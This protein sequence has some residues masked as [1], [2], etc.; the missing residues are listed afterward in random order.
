MQLSELAKNVSIKI[1]GDARL[2]WDKRDEWQ[3][4]SNGYSCT[5]AYKKRRMKLD[6][7]MGSA[8]AHPPTSSDVLDVLL[9]DASTVENAS[10]FEDWAGE[11]G[12]DVDSRTAEKIYRAVSRQT[13]KLRDLLGDD[14]QAFLEAE[15]D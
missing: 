9:S 5:L 1:N 2:P 3:Q 6:F 8:I 10:S 15:R 7:F 11:L 12:Y 13:Q 4:N 14:Y